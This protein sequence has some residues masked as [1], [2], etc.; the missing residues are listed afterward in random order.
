[1]VFLCGMTRSKNGEGLAVYEATI[2][3]WKVKVSLHQL[4]VS[5]VSCAR[6]ELLFHKKLCHRSFCFP[7]VLRPFG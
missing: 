7:F 1:M 3:R 5:Q 4:T 6:Q 2:S